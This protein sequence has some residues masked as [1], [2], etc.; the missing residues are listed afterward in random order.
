MKNWLNAARLY[1]YLLYRALGASRFNL[2]KM[3]NILLM[4]NAG[5]NPNT[6][7]PARQFLIAKGLVFASEENSKGDHW[8]YEILNPGTFQSFRSEWRTDNPAEVSMGEG[9]SFLMA[10][11]FAGE[12]PGLNHPEFQTED[13]STSA[14]RQHSRMVTPKK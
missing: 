12:Y 11:H 4:K 3:S 14:T 1:D 10:D 8:T 13:S 5:L 6:M 2:T 9:S 7:K